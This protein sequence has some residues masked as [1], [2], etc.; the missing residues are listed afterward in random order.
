[1]TQTTDVTVLGLGDMG[2]AL[3]RCLVESGRKTTVWNR[4][5]AR[6]EPLVAEGATHASD[7]ADAIAASPV[8]IVCVS[9]Y[10]ATR[11][12]LETSAAEEALAGRTLI[13]L[14]SGSPAQAR[15]LHEWARARSVAYLDGCIIAFPSQMGSEAALLLLAGDR[16]AY[17]SHRST[18]R[19]LSPRAD[20]LGD[21]AGGA[22]ALDGAIL[23][24]GFGTILGLVNGAALC[25][26]AD[27]PVENLSRY[28]DHALGT[29]APFAK[30]L[31]AKIANEDLEQTEA[32]LHTWAA[33]LDHMIEAL[34]GTGYSDEFPRFT[35]ALFQRAEQ[36][37]LGGHD[38]AAL[39]ELLRPQQG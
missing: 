27:L 18:L 8:A 14:T 22:S 6:A 37:G 2:A 28:T 17:E 19:T 9:D 15:A 10:D 35:R 31:L 13:Q 7:V 12:Q 30:F 23:S 21:D 34:G 1:M 25:E 5:A 29:F 26:A 24:V 11:A 4:T 36:R 38:V 32:A 3:A 33:G 16:E 39:I 20:Y